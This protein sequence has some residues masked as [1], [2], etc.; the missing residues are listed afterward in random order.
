MG[1]SLIMKINLAYQ[2][3][4]YQPDLLEFLYQT[5]FDKW[6]NSYQINNSEFLEGEQ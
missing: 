3:V 5:N 2:K 4:L 6:S 1:Q